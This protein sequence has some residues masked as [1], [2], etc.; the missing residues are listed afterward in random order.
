VLKIIFMGTSAFAIPSLLA[1]NSHHQL[2]AVVS[3][4]DRPKGRGKKLAFTPVKECALANQLAVLQFGDIK[5]EEAY[6]QIKALEADL[7]VVVSYGQIIPQNI[8][9]YPSLGCI[10]LHASLLPKYRGAAPIQRALMA[11]EKLTG[12]TTMFMDEGLD[13]G[14]IIKQVKIEISEDMDHGELETI[15]AQ[16]G[17]RLL[18]DTISDLQKGS[19]ERRIQDDSEATYAGT[20]KK[21]DEIIKWSDSAFAI[22]NRVR[23]L[24]PLPGAF[25]MINGSKIKIFKTRVVDTDER[26]EIGRVCSVGNEGFTVQTG[27]G[28]L[29]I[30]EIQKEGKKRM[31]CRDFLRGFKLNS[32]DILG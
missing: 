27:N 23:A 26:C 6:E 2:S 17:A 28:I 25:T 14:D 4:P 10:N 31:L 11:G 22:H 21:E 24:S 3:Q 16:K 1:I 13:T 32:G 19:Y 12:I 8:L 18:L 29:E 7:I 15:L 9:E 20:L 30:L 5:K